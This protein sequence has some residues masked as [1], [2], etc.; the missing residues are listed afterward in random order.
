MTST[1][2]PPPKPLDVTGDIFHNWNIWK[3]RIDAVNEVSE[4]LISG[5]EDVF[6]GLGQLEGIAYRLQLKPDSPMS[7]SGPEP[8]ASFPAPETKSGGPPRRHG[9]PAD[10][11]SA[12]AAPRPAQNCAVLLTPCG[13]GRRS[14]RVRVPTAIL[15]SSSSRQAGPYWKTPALPDWEAFTQQL[16]E[17]FGVSTVRTKVAKK[18]LGCQVAA[19]TENTMSE[20]EPI[21]EAARRHVRGPTAAHFDFSSA[22]EWFTWLDDLDDYLFD[23]GRNRSLKTMQRLGTCLCVLASALCCS[24]QGSGGGQDHWPVQFMVTVGTPRTFDD[25]RAFCGTERYLL[26]LHAGINASRVQETLLR[27]GL[28]SSYVWLNLRMIQGFFHWL[29]PIPQLFK[30][31]YSSPYGDAI[32]AHNY[33]HGCAVLNTSSGAIETR[34][35]DEQH[36]FVCIEDK[37]LRPLDVSGEAVSVELTS[38]QTPVLLSWNLPYLRLACR[39]QL[40][41]GTVLREARPGSYA[42]AHVW[43]KNGVFLD[44]TYPSL[45]PEKVSEPNAY[46][47]SNVSS[48]GRYRCGLKALPSGSIAWS[49]VVTVVLEDFDTYRLTGHLFPSVDPGPIQFIGGSFISFARNIEAALTG[50]QV[51]AS[52][53]YSGITTDDADRVNISLF[54]YYKRPELASIANA[55]GRERDVFNDSTALENL[56]AINNIT[57][58]LHCNFLQQGVFTFH[59]EGHVGLA[60]ST[61]PCLTES[62]HVVPRYCDM[63]F[64]SE[65]TWAPFD[66][67]TCKA[68]TRSRAFDVHT[69]R[70]HLLCSPR[71]CAPQS[72]SG[73]WSE[74]RRL[75]NSRRGYLASNGLRSTGAPRFSSRRSRADFSAA[76]LGG[77]AHPERSGRVEPGCRVTRFSAF[78]RTGVPCISEATRRFRG[79]GASWRSVLREARQRNATGVHTAVTTSFD[80]WTDIVKKHGYFQSDSA[81]HPQIL[82]ALKT[83]ELLVPIVLHEGANSDSCFMVSPVQGHLQPTQ[84][85]DIVTQTSCSHELDGKCAFRYRSF[86]RGLNPCPKGGWLDLSSKNS[87]LWLNLLPLDYDRAAEKCRA[88]NGH[89]AFVDNSSLSYTL[90][91]LLA[92]NDVPRQFDRYWIGLQRSPDGVYVWENGDPL[93]EFAWH[94]RTDYRHGAGTLFV[95]RYSVQEGMTLRYSLEDPRRKLPSICQAP[96]QTGTP[97]LRVEQRNSDRRVVLTCRVSAEIIPGSVLWFKDGIAVQ[98]DRANTPDGHDT[99]LVIEGATPTS[100]YL[101]GYYWCEGMSVADFG[102]VESRKTLVRFPGIKTYACTIPLV[103]QNPKLYDFTSVLALR[104]ASDFRRNFFYA[105]RDTVVE[106]YHMYELQVVDIAQ[107]TATADVVRFLVFFNRLRRLPRTTSHDEDVRIID[108]LKYTIRN[109]TS[110]LITTPPVLPDAMSIRSTEMCFEDT[111]MHDTGLQKELTWPTTPTGGVAIPRETCIQGDG[112]PVVRRCEG[113][114]TTGAYWGNVQGTCERL[115]SDTTLDLRNLSLASCGGIT[116]RLHAP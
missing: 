114:F 12:D 53:S 32:A 109:S 17:I 92:P 78:T 44:H 19:F 15:H 65:P 93:R 47:H 42:Y 74:A 52:W 56:V 24:S 27:N 71:H 40:R 21:V 112:L 8:C 59:A 41:N 76:R 81:G 88:S 58:V 37:Q 63:T 13:I 46:T 18:K 57:D 91:L 35:C 89:L 67:S 69:D 111:T 101:Q 3:K 103:G 72:V 29:D 25:A 9:H 48:Q 113:S 99:T 30:Q 87:C 104:F 107:D 60:E 98:G 10:K 28:G 75:C 43:T 62:H 26:N 86:F 90:A 16:R 23:S 94:P 5:F 66:E 51:S 1:L 54:L 70:H 20:P 77:A 97:W 11:R 79:G 36:P 38:N 102:P 116:S 68:G 100:P 73:T 34:P 64:E 106:G 61:P 84:Y 105:I 33:H 14:Q 50:Q 110:R 4:I 80:G 55:N 108:F 39:A 2:L 22:S 83:S 115:A 49:N 85:S 6:Q 96:L 7:T 45:Q 31:T 82:E 95:D